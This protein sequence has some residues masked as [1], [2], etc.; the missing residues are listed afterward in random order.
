MYIKQMVQWWSFRINDHCDGKRYFNNREENLNKHSAC[1]LYE[2]DLLKCETCL[3][4]CFCWS[5]SVSDV[6][7]WSFLMFLLCFLYQVFWNITTVVCRVGYHSD[8]K[9]CNNSNKVINKNW[10]IQ[11]EQINNAS[12]NRCFSIK[13]GLA[14][15]AWFTVTALV[16]RFGLNET[17]LV[18]Y[19]PLYNI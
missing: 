3:S 10:K 8:R 15:V 9:N 17:K 5:G 13:C 1:I 7:V 16:I 12:L 2:H 6:L 11:S 18:L 14:Y 19:F 4:T